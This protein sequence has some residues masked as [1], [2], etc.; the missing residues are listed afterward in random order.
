MIDRTIE[1]RYYN[2]IFF[3]FA[4]NTLGSFNHAFTLN[5]IK[6]QYEWVERLLQN[7]KVQP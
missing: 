5:T 4:Q 2:L 3:I 1:I 7:D 6:K